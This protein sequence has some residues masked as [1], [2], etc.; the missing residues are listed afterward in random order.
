MKNMSNK[1]R[2]TFSKKFKIT[3][4]NKIL[5]RTIGQGHN[6]TKKENKQ[7]LRKKKLIQD[8]DLILKYKNY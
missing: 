6:F 2:K 4:N 5:R 7:L 8:R 3:R 1:T